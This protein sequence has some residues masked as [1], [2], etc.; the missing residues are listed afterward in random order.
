MGGGD[1]AGRFTDYY[2]AWLDHLADVA[3]GDSISEDDERLA[4]LDDVR[5]ELGSVALN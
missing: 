1:P 2:P 3:F 5:R 4:L